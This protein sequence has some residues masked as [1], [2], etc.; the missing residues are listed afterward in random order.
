MTEQYETRHRPLGT[1]KRKMQKMRNKQRVSFY[2]VIGFSLLFVIIV[3]MDILC[4]DDTDH[5][6]T[7][8]NNSDHTLDNDENSVWETAR[9]LVI[10]LYRRNLR[11]YSSTLESKIVSR[12]EKFES[13][14]VARQEEMQQLMMNISASMSKNPL[15]RQ[16]QASRAEFRY[17]N[18]ASLSI[19]TTLHQHRGHDA[20]WQPVNGTHHKFWVYSAFYDDREKPLVRVI[21]TTKTKKSEKVNENV[22]KLLLLFFK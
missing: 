16:I 8:L 4:V 10:P 14:L 7:E 17:K 2:L 19:D 11:L 15:V 9:P 22:C 1:I 12:K 20:V 18:R 13:S 3:M 6:D 5:N 21:A